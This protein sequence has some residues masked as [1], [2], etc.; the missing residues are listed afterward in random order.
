MRVIAYKTLTSFVETLRGNRDR[1]AVD[2]ALVT[3]Y[4]ETK[5]AIWQNPAE[6]KQAYRSASLVGADRVVF[7]ICG[8]KY[9]LVVA[10]NY[11]RQVVF[12]KWIGSH[13]EYDRI[14]V[15]RVEHGD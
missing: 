6:I 8:N 11:Q 7:N 9:R 3:W 10:I 5:K 1:D 13:A 15:R 4:H 2:A 12:I 14:D